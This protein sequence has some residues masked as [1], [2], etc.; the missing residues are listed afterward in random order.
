MIRI[1]V[2]EDD[3]QQRQLLKKHL[4]RFA[5]ETGVELDI[6][7]FEDGAALLFH[8]QPVYDIIL[9]DIEMPR[10]NGME[11]AERIR[12]LDSS[13]IL[14]FATS[15]AQYAVQGYK[16]RAQSYILKPVNYYSLYPELQEA[17]NTLKNGEAKRPFCC[18]Q[19]T[20]W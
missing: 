16:V 15:M 12:A 13:V 11:A 20:D 6:V 19:R 5:Q 4:L 10:T 3:V 8:Y 18:P 9:L 7:E 14:I 2:A 17:L 1:A